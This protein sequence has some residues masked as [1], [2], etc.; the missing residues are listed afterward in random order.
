MKTEIKVLTLKKLNIIVN[1]PLDFSQNLA[2]EDYRK[3]SQTA[4]GQKIFRVYY[5]NRPALFG[6]HLF[7]GGSE[8]KASAWSAGDLSS[9]PGSGRSPG[10]G[11]GNPLLYSDINNNKEL[12]GGKDLAISQCP[13]WTSAAVGAQLAEEGASRTTSITQQLVA[14]GK[15]SSIQRLQFPHL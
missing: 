1:F 8:V 7:P 12:G 9:I 4:V 2:K 11:N 3:V 13:P 10:E 14:L 5:H 6:N 15:A